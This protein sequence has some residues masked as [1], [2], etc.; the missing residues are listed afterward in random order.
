[1]A[2]R[3]IHFSPDPWPKPKNPPPASHGLHPRLLKLNPFQCSKKTGIRASGTGLLWPLEIFFI[4]STIIPLDP[5]FGTSLK[6]GV[7]MHQHNLSMPKS[8]RLGPSSEGGKF[9]SFPLSAFRNFM[10]EEM[11]PRLFGLIRGKPVKPAGFNV[12]SQGL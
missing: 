7:Q 6:E 12:N 9:L 2:E 8:N 1:L 10:L 4:Y 5:E 11:G 3:F